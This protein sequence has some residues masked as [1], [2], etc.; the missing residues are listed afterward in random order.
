[1]FPKCPDYSFWTVFVTV[2]VFTGNRFPLE[3]AVSFTIYFQFNIFF[4]DAYAA[5]ILC[6]EME[7]FITFYLDIFGAFATPFNRPGIQR[8]PCT[9]IGSE[10]HEML[11]KAASSKG[12]VISEHKGIQL[13]ENQ[14]GSGLVICKKGYF[15]LKRAYGKAS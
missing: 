9:F 1:V 11:N 4:I 7:V 5:E 14:R 6:Q 13:Q 3:I 12:Q 10:I 2:K 15:M 8:T